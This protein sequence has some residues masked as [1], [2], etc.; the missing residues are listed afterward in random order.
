MGSWVQARAFKI[1]YIVRDGCGSI[2][3]YST[4]RVHLPIAPPVVA[5][6]LANALRSL[7]RV[8]DPLGGWFHTY[9]REEI[10]HTKKQHEQIMSQ[11]LV[12]NCGRIACAVVGPGLLLCILVSPAATTCNQNS[13]R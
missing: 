1:Q 6:M 10:Q 13:R 4:W 5:G 9:G 7:A 2:L 3:L 12:L 11:A 8:G